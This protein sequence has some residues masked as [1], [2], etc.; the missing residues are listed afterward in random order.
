MSESNSPNVPSSMIL[1]GGPIDARKTL[2]QLMN[3]LKV[4][5]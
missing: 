4:K 5:V 3:L 1:M 2:Q